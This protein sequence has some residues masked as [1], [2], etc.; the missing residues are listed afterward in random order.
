MKLISHRGNIVEKCVERE[1]TLPY[2]NSAL[3]A[4]YDV[5]IDVWY[6]REVFMLGH[7]APMQVVLPDFLN[8]DK[9]WCHAKNIEALQR[10][11]NF[12]IHC[13]WHEKDIYTIT[14]KGKI[15]VYPDQ[16]LIAEAVAV[17]PEIWKKQQDLTNCYA[18]CSDNIQKYM[19]V[20]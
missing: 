2:I 12:G 1:N 4:G 7:D 14:S 8:I 13:F 10:M 20:K 15:W 5:E 17:L 16:P 9:L 3:E 18:I 11:L 6:I 19:R